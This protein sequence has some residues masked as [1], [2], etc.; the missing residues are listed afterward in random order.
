M[1]RMQGN[2]ASFHLAETCDQICFCQRSQIRTSSDAPSRKGGLMFRCEVKRRERELA[3][4]MC[5]AARRHDG[6]T[7]SATCKRHRRVKIFRDRDIGKKSCRH[8][9]LPQLVRELSDISVQKI[10]S[11]NVQ[12]IRAGTLLHQFDTGREHARDMVKRR[13]GRM[14]M[15]DNTTER[16]HFGECFGVKPS[17]ADFYAQSVPRYSPRRRSQ[18]AA[19]HRAPQMVSCAVPGADARQPAQ[20]NS[21]DGERHTSPHS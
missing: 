17:H 16:N 3:D 15:F 8:Y 1:C 2:G 4:G 20:R 19:L 10:H 18:L 5:L 11:A 12:R 9:A 6:D 13:V 14:L 7:S 21:R